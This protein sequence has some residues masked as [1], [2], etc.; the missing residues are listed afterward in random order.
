[1]WVFGLCIFILY[2]PLVWIR[3][4]EPLSKLLVFAA[5]LILI[6]VVTTSS[7]ALG[8]ASDQGGPGEGYVAVN[9]EGYWGTI[10]FAF[11]MYEGIGSL[12]PVMRETEKPEIAPYIAIAAFGT[13]FTMHVTFSSICYY[14]WGENLTEPV[15][16]EML[17]ADNVF[18]QA[19][20]L[21][22][23]INLFFSF[24]LIAWPTF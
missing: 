22:F 3:R 16:T 11:F 17:P 6:G 14:A 23:C 2:S 13:L 8:V 15:V 5:L 21:L 12:L 24:P 10:G 7:F 4:L 20:K 18:V 1:M 19:M 9:Q